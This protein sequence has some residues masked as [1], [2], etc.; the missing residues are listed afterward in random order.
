MERTISF[1]KQDLTK[2]Q[3]EEIIVVLP[4]RA[5]CFIKKEE[6]IY[7]YRPRSA[8]ITLNAEGI[9]NLSKLYAITVYADDILIHNI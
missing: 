4:C 8:V 9:N 7:H 3:M 2:S 6:D 1:E 5:D